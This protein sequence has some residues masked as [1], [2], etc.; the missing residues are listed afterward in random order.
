MTALLFPAS[1]HTLSL[2]AAQLG[3]TTS[4][5]QGMAATLQAFA[6][7]RPVRDANGA[8]WWLS[9]TT[10]PP[11]PRQDAGGQTGQ[12]S[13]GSHTAAQEESAFEEELLAGLSQP[14]APPPSS[15]APTASLSGELQ[16][17][18]GVGGGGGTSLIRNIP[19]EGGGLVG[20]TLTLTPRKGD[21][22]MVKFDGQMAAGSVGPFDA[23]WDPV[24]VVAVNALLLSSL[25]LSD[26]KVYEP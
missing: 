4:L 7:P 5:H 20:W 26:T 9:P 2:A 24:R 14:H 10:S 19:G 13:S 17:P 3:L 12:A 25:E 1:P 23:I 21:A 8:E 15:P 18:R 16:T 22:S 11:T 6:T